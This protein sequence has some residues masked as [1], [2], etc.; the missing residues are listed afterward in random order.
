MYNDNSIREGPCIDCLKRVLHC[1][2]N[3]KDYIDWRNDLLKTKDK[4][5]KDP[6]NI[7]TARY[8]KYTSNK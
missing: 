7:Q 2:S 3:C 5:K 8:H 6:R 4:I 1:H